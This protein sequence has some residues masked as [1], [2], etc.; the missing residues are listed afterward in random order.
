M[1]LLLLLLLLLLQEYKGTN[2]VGSNQYTTP[3]THHLHSGLK[4]TTS[5][6][7][8]SLRTD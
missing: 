1:L 4:L 6:H 7:Q 8:V 2:V 5:L 3:S